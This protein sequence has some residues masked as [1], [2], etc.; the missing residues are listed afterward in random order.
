MNILAITP[1]PIKQKDIG[2]GG[3]VSL[4]FRGLKKKLEKHGHSLTIVSAWNVLD[5]ATMSW[6]PNFREIPATKRNLTLLETEITRND[7]I[8]APDLSIGLDII[9][10]CNKHKKPFIYLHL[11]AVE[12]FAPSV[13]P[14]M[15][16]IVVPAFKF[17]GKMVS[18]MS[19]KVLTVSKWSQN[20]RLEQGWKIDGVINQNYKCDLFLKFDAQQE[21]SDLRNSILSECPGKDKIIMFAGRFSK[22]KRIELLVPAKPDNCILLIIGDGAN[23]EDTLKLHDIENG[24]IVKRGMVEQNILRKYYKAVDALVSASRMESF[25]MT[26]FEASL[27]GA[28]SIVEN[29]GGFVE[30]ITQL[31]CGELVSFDDYATTKKI[32]QKWINK[33]NSNNRNTFNTERLDF[34][35]QILS[36]KHPVKFNKDFPFYIFLCAYRLTMMLFSIFVWKINVGYI[37]ECQ[38]V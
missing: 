33:I 8:I 16:L 28:V 4:T 21:I 20:T 37:D 3:G 29:F 35:D 5:Y 27:C 15:A 22:E 24:V 31:K 7:I 34:M 19:S 1:V 38:V 30:Q 18:K 32:I 17:Y 12:L 14:N 2:Y 13:I 25:G 36:T 26:V 6:Y 10:L 11:T 9:L 23:Y